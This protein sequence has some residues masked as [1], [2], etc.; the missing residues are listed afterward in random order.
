MRILLLA[1]AALTT[2]AAPVYA[3]EQAAKATITMTNFNFAPDDLHLHAGQRV[4]I[5]FVN[6]GSGGHDFTA[7]E[8]FSAAAMDSADRDKVGTKGRV[9]L[10]KGESLD[11]TLVPKAGTYKAHC[12]HFMH[13]TLGMTGRIH[14]D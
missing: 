11:V 13:S 4:T 7:T 1:A 5:H 12:S 9:S 10:G 8:F 3:A 2:V 6:N 14:V